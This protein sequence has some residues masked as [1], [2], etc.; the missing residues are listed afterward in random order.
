LFKTA[1][2]LQLNKKLFEKLGI[3]LVGISSGSEKS[4]LDFA[5]KCSLDF[6]LLVDHDKRV[7]K[8]FN[9]VSVFGGVK[10][11]VVLIS[12]GRKILYE[13]EVI[14]FRYQTSKQLVRLFENI[15]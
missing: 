8:K 3:E 6:P 1:Y 7:M 4:H 10:R 2:R 9:A 5:S 13:S 11:K 14:P 15:E 12:E